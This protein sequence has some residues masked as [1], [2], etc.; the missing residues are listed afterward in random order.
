[1]L[2]KPGS[3]MKAAPTRPTQQHRCTISKFLSFPGC[4]PWVCHV[5]RF[6]VY[7]SP[8]ACA[9]PWLASRNL[10]YTGWSQWLPPKATSTGCLVVPKAIRDLLWECTQHWGQGWRWCQL[11]VCYLLLLL[12]LVEGLAQSKEARAQSHL[13]IL[14]PLWVRLPHHSS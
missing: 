9:E 5:P 1:M 10:R 11:P 7:I 8:T 2:P 3:L 14:G 13:A 4:P 6:Q 12:V